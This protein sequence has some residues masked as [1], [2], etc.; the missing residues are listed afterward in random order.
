[1]IRN[2]F[3]ACFGTVSALFLL[4]AQGAEKKGVDLSK[5]PP[6]SDKQGVTYATDIKPLFEKSCTKCHDGD[7]PKGRLRLDSLAGALKGGEDGKVISPGDS[8]GSM[9]VHNVAQAGDKDLYMP[10]P[11]NKEKLQPLT[12]EQI[13]LIRAWID[14]GA[15]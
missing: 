8:A 4:S 1:M 10:P 12:K 15:K 5:I 14:Q 2:C 3:I 6:A 13:G 11:R 9:L 7:K